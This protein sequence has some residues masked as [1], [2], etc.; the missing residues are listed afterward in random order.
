MGAQWYISLPPV[1]RSTESETIHTGD[2]SYLS[3][4]QVLM[5]PD[6]PSTRD[7]FLQY[8]TEITLD[9]NTAH[10]KLSLCDGNRRATLKSN[11]QRYPDHPDRFSVCQV[12]SRESLTGRHYWEVE[13]SGGWWARVAVSYRDIQ[14][15][16]FSK[17]CLF[18]YNDKSW[19]LDCNSNNCSFLFNSVQ[20]Q[21][22][23]RFTD[24]L[25]SRIGVYL[26]HSAGVLKFYSI[27]GSTMSLVHR[28]QTRFTQPLYAGLWIYNTEST[29][30][31]LKVK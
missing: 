12:L 6:E 27:S 14:R 21:V 13:L 1:I 23:D 15:K 22:S 18:G 29:A 4:V 17:E 8:S 30:C 16:G 7:D 26:D 2:R 9:P 31:F 24:P 10:T 25:R 3:P 20:S 28:V 5:A 11:D 19:A